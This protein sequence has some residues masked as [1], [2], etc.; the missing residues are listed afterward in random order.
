MRSQQS[1]RGLGSTPTSTIAEDLV[2]TGNVTSKGEIHLDG[3]V[4]GDIH[5]LSLVVSEKS[6]I[7]GNVVAEDVAIRGSIIGSVRALRVALHPQCHVEGDL[8]HHSLT[9]AQGAYFD[10]EARP[11][12]PLSLS[13]E[14]PEAHATAK[15]RLV[16]EHL[17]QPTPSKEVQRSA[18]QTEGS[19]ITR[20]AHRDSE[21]NQ[22]S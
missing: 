15:P 20:I 18:A 4:R 5:C 14:E 3:Q 10:G 11:C 12:N 21:G 7:E 13:Q 16:A 9:I 8:F 17:G 1:A 6:Q 19:R 22:T 2:I